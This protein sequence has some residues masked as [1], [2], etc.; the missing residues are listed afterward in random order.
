MALVLTRKPGESIIIGDDVTI[1]VIS[2]GGNQVK[3]AIDAPNHISIH[4]EE[5]YDRIQNG[6]KLE[7]R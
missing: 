5:V 3:L 6:V 4:R 1:T 2:N 7:D